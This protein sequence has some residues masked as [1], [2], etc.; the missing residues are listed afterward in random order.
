MTNQ[1]QLDEVKA[2][3]A[4][5]QPEIA[6]AKE[7]VEKAQEKLEKAEGDSDIQ[8]CSILLQSA[9]AELTR[10]GQK[11]AMLME[12]ENKLTPPANNNQMSTADR[13]YQF[14]RGRSDE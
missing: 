6:I 7:K 4:A 12:K 11:E 2:A 8:R 3:I 10:L 9:S 5:I 1:Q 14:T 13:S